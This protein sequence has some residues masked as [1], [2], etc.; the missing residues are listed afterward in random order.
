MPSL[1]PPPRLS[2]LHCWPRPLLAGAPWRGQGRRWRWRSHGGCWGGSAWRPTRRRRRR[3]RRLLLRRPWSLLVSSDSPSPKHISLSRGSLDQPDTGLIFL[4]C[5]PRIRDLV[6]LALLLLAS[7]W[8]RQPLPPCL[9]A[10]HFPPCR[11]NAGGGGGG[12]LR[13]HCEVVSARRLS[14]DRRCVSSVLLLVS[15]GF[16]VFD[17]GNLGGIDSCT[18]LKLPERKHLADCGGKHCLVVLCFWLG[19]L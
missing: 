8:W 10:S 11:L 4:A 16:V 1:R 18:F 3:R 6:D 15:H 19:V 2:R 12:W 9:R 5:L 13:S 7:D 17:L 14:D